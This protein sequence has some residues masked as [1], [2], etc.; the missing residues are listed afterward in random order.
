MG[1]KKSQGKT[2]SEMTSSFP[3]FVATSSM[4]FLSCSTVSYGVWYTNCFMYPHK[5]KSRGLR[6]IST[7]P[8]SCEDLVKPRTHLTPIFARLCLDFLLRHLKFRVP[9]L[10]FGWFFG[11]PSPTYVDE[12]LHFLGDAEQRHWK[13]YGLVNSDRRKFHRR[14]VELQDH[15]QRLWRTYIKTTSVISALV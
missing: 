3:M 13:F 9:H 11:D 8:P 12:I 15:F 7:Y 10:V 14:D 1:I 5:K 4:R 6:P 2:V